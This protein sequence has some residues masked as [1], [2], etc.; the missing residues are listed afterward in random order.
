MTSLILLVHVNFVLSLL[1][2]SLVILTLND[3]DFVGRRSD[4]R[5]HYWQEAQTV[6]DSENDNEEVHAEVVKLEESSWGEGKHENT[7]ELGRG[8]SNNDRAAHVVHGLHG[9][10]LSRSLLLEEIH[11][12]V[13]AELDTEAQTCDEVHDKHSVHFYWVAAKYDIHHP[14][15]AHELE[16]R[17]E[18]A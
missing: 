18:D 3:L 11:A 16:E 9:A 8:N 1:H 6:E 12:D 13:V 4:E 2:R 5:E 17:E 7:K 14:A 10:N 15:D